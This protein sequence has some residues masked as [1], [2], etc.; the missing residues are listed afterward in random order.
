MEATFTYWAQ[1]P[2]Q[3]EQ[4]RCDNAVGVIRNAIGQHNVLGA[5]LRSHSIRVFVQGSYRNRVNVR[6]DSDVDVGALYTG[7]FFGT[8]PH[9]SDGES[10]GIPAAAYR[11]GQF[12]TDLQQAL[13]E[14]LGSSM[15]ARGNKSIKI[16]ETSY[17]VE[18]D[19][20]PFFEHRMYSAPGSYVPGVALRPDK[21]SLPV[22]NYPEA[23]FSWWPKE[24][25]ENG[26][27]K[28]ERTR[29]RYRG[30][31]RILKKL[32]NQMEDGGSP[33]ARAIPGYLLECLTWNAPDSCFDR[34]GWY[35]RVGAV[36]GYL[37]AQI[38]T[39][40]GWQGWCE[41]DGIK[42]LFTQ[43]Q[44]WTLRQARDFIG[45]TWAYLGA[46]S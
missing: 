42:P 24:H 40:T 2:S 1:S 14:Y 21:S 11:Y 35:P 25:Y 13:S 28:H 27:D 19:V 44:P 46:Q 12:K 20:T 3:S 33:A 23:L 7:S 36:L 31:V 22:V 29:R 39:G 41:V 8:Y 30:L 9:G 6:A 38:D 37:G 15:V 45:A 5:M 10:W 26:L 32:R 34:Y 18:A 43:A 4:T 16:R 17:H